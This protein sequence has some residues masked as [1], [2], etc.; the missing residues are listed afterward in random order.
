MREFNRFAIVL[1]MLDGVCSE[2]FFSFFRLID[3]TENHATGTAVERGVTNPTQNVHSTLGQ[4]CVQ[5]NLFIPPVTPI[6]KKVNKS[7]KRKLIESV[8]GTPDQSSFAGVES[9]DLQ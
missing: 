3:C 6:P 9:M 5:K 8:S 2:S 1:D 7:A 4:G